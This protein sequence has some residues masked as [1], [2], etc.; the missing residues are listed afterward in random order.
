MT[1]ASLEIF[2]QGWPG[3]DTVCGWGSTLENTENIRYMLPKLVKEC[4]IRSINDAGC[5]DL[6]W[7]KNIDLG[8]V[9]YI[10]YDIY[11]RSTWTKLREEG[12]KLEI[13]DITKDTLRRVDLTIVRDVFIHLP[14]RLILDALDK[15]KLTTT[16]LLAT[17]F[18]RDESEDKAVDNFARISGTS[19]HH[20]KHNLIKPPFNLGIPD[21]IIPENYPFKSTSLWRLI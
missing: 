8:P 14:N 2:E 20:S 7:I 9:D 5:G 10:G 21:V 4:N 18:V 12:W 17:N 13:A 3:S 19:L 1:K 11:E 6:F 16:Y 15:L